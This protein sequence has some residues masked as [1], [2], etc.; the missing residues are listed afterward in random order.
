MTREDHIVKESDI[1]PARMDGTCFYCRAP[2]HTSH[3]FGCVIRSKTVMVEVTFQILKVVPED[4]D[5]HMIEFSMN[6]S[7]SCCNNLVTNLS[8]Q[9]ERM[10]MKEGSC[11]CYHTKGKFLRDATQEDED[12]FGVPT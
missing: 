8:D 10:D 7:S 6:D 4:W 9:V 1:R 2:L 12:T 11:M 3:T 5:K